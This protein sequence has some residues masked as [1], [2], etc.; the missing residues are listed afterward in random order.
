MRKLLL[1]LTVLCAVSLITQ[2]APKAEDFNVR[3]TGVAVAKA[4]GDDETVTPLPPETRIVVT[5]GNLAIF[6]LEYDVP[7]DL[8]TL[9]FL[10]A[11]Y[12]KADTSENPFGSSGSATY[13]GKGKLQRILILMPESYGKPLLLKSVRITGEIE[14]AKGAPRNDSFFICDAAVNVLFA[15]EKDK[16]ATEVTLLE[17]RPAP[18]P[19]PTLGIKPPDKTE[20]NG[21][22]PK[23]STPPGFTDNL[24]QALAK[25]KAEGKLVYACFSGSDWCGW[26]MRLEKEVFS[27]TDF[28]A[29][30]KND[31]VPVFIDAP[32]DKSLLSEHARS[33]NPKLIAK[34]RID[35]FPTARILDGDGKKIGE[36]GYR[37]GG[38]AAYVEHL[39]TFR[40]K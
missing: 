14:A 39:M 37:K 4:E 21:G 12:P 30:I 19:D 20:K 10:G 7:A 33:A 34:Y 18:A 9:L 36:T 2:A 24:D 28:L 27:Q 6:F 32:H 22:K 25:A 23:S 29:G 3:L 8:K 17:P 5:P 1:V 35:G 38:A 26:C 11:N 40:K 15:K 31:F 13:S 16:T